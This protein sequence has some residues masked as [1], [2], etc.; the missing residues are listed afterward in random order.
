[1]QKNKIKKLDKN[2]SYIHKYIIFAC[3]EK[4]LILFNTQKKVSKAIFIT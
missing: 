1:M 2:S 3:K 4:Q